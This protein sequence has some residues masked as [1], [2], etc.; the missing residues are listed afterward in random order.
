MRNLSSFPT[1][2]RSAA[3]SENCKKSLECLTC[4]QPVSMMSLWHSVS[5]SFQAPLPV[6]TCN[7]HTWLDARA[8]H[9]L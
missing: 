3:V 8:T 6:L 7:Q 1:L 4:V 9:W 5:V 2:D